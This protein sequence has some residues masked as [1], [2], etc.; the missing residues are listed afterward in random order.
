MTESV[1]AFTRVLKARATV[2]P[3]ARTMTSPRNKKFLNPLITAAFLSGKLK[4]RGRSGQPYS[5]A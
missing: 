2:N 5:S 1:K 4:P 3:I